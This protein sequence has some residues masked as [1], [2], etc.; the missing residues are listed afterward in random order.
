MT[1]ILEGQCIVTNDLGECEGIH[2]IFSVEMV[3]SHSNIEKLRPYNQHRELPV[4]LRRRCY[5]EH[6]PATGAFYETSLLGPGKRYG[7]V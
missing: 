1:Q 4:R 7:L 6:E 3:C 2:S 5:A